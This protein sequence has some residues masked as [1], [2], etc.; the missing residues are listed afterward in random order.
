MAFT[1]LLSGDSILQRRLNSRDD[2]ELKPLLFRAAEAG[3]PLV[4]CFD[5][6]S[7]RCVIAP[8]CVLRG[9]LSEAMEAFYRTLDGYTLAD[10]LRPDRR[11]IRLLPA[12]A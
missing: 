2:A 7:S 1:L 8:A 12:A 10:L 9:A 4:E 5:R 3:P 11:L 6:G